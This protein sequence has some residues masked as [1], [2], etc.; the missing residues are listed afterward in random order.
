ML[1]CKVLLNE[2]YYFEFFKNNLMQFYSLQAI[3]KKVI[4]VLSFLAINLIT[5]HIK[6]C[7]DFEF[8]INF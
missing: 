6:F 1:A 3:K 4:N 8:N 2:K 7:L 5:Y